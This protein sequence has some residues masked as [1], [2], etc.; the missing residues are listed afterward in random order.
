MCEL[1][2][3]KKTNRR[4]RFKNNDISPVRAPRGGQ[5]NFSPLSIFYYACMKELRKSRRVLK[6]VR[7]LCK[8]ILSR[9]ELCLR[10]YDHF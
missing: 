1:I 8:A 6:S 2:R 4:G 5:M 7:F 9:W 10:A 3:E